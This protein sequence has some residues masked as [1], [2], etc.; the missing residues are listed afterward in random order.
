MTTTIIMKQQKGI[1][2]I[3][4]SSLIILI[5][6]F[7][8]L[9]SKDIRL[10]I[11]V[12][13]S[14]EI[15][16]VQNKR[17]AL[18]TNQS[19]INADGVPTAELLSHDIRIDLR[20][21]F[22]PEHGYY[23]T[24]PAGEPV[25]NDS[26]FGTPIVSLYGP[27]KIP[28]K[29]VL[30][31][32]DAVVVDI[33]D[34]GVR[35]YT[36]ISS[37]LYLIQGCAENNIEVIILDRPNP[38]GGL[39]VDGNTPEKKFKSFVSLVPTTYIH[40]CT[41]GELALMINGEIWT[42]NKKQCNLT[43]VRM[44]G[45]ERWMAW[46]DTGLMWIPTS[47]HVPTANSVRG[48]STLGTI[49]ELGIVSIGIGTTSPFGYIGSPYLNFDNLSVSYEGAYLQ[50]T[51]YRPFY[52]MFS[53]KDVPGFYLKFNLSNHFKPYTTGLLI[54]NELVKNN[55]ELLSDKNLKSQSINMF[56]K[57]TGT[58]K[59]L[60]AIESNLPNEMIVTLA[61]DGLIDFLNIRTKYL[62]Y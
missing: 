5:S 18:F 45:W 29:K 22:V 62:L 50:K 25:S 4:I 7:S 43:I 23:T 1:L 40:G 57:I 44:E 42:E 61:N 35:S 52:G 46:E 47:P 49:G 59:I 24:I 20:K 10:G 6:N 33:Q 30:S 51:F 15:N 54:L 55:P 38:L 11:D 56:N 41:I 8:P 58:D 13:M 21:I 3:I 17:I 14:D 19:G 60:K 9:L 36:Y 27:L 28:D 26:I 37:L 2:L 12:L 53:G 16:V 34:I 39:I 32:I 31:N 48:I